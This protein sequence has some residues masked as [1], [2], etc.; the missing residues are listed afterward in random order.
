MSEW[1]GLHYRHVHVWDER[2]LKLTALYWER[3]YRFDSAQ[4]PSD[5]PPGISRTEAVLSAD[6]FLKATTPRKDDFEWAADQFLS[7]VEDVDLSAYRL[8]SHQVPEQ[9]AWTRDRDLADEL[10]DWYG[11]NPAPQDLFTPLAAEERAAGQRRQA[12][13]VA[14]P[15][16][17]SRW[18]MTLY[19]IRRL[20]QMGL[21][22]PAS[23]GRLLMH[24]TLVHAYL[25]LLGTHTAPR[26]GAVPLA[27]ATFDH[28][29]TGLAARRLVAGVLGD[30]MPQARADE[31]T[32]LLINL[33]VS[34][35]LPRNIDHISAEQ[36]IDFRDRYA[37][38]R[39]RFRDAAEAMV[40]EAAHLEDITDPDVLLDHLQARYDTRIRPAL[41]DLERAMRG[42]RFQTAWGAI[43]LQAAAPPAV[44]TAL[45]LATHPSPAQTA[46]VG[47]GSFAVG[48]WAA[49]VQ[50]RHQREQALTSAPMA[51]LHRLH[52]GLTP[53]GLL[54]RAHHAARHL[55]PRRLPPHGHARPHQPPDQ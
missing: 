20:E 39:A 7:A 26:H 43:N 52:T 34:A 49:A 30:P 24:S 11:F 32:A 5:D 17:L 38:E 46:T 28:A 25:L 9:P 19:F 27:R 48:V 41:E 8:S 4:N 1:F 13:Q 42:Q 53:Q 14:D 16:S 18:K 2:W 29:V 3:V 54:Q 44:S 22:E 50:Q 51:Y 33:A 55:A 47:L 10:P 37:G 35:V 15:R 6:G 36:I 12:V 40:D 23:H 21:A 45:L 31:R